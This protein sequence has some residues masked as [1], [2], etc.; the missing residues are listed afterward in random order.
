MRAGDEFSG[1]LNLPQADGTLASV[2]VSTIFGGYSGPMSFY[3]SSALKTL[4][5][6]GAP[7]RLQDDNII[8]L[9]K[10]FSLYGYLSVI[11]PFPTAI[12]PLTNAAGG[13]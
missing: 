11:V 10:A 2:P 6:P 5:S 12:V 8:N 4:E 9:S 7:L 3:D 1:T 13:E